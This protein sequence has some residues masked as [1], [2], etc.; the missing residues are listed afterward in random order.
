MKKEN[1]KEIL[2]EISK[3]RDS[4]HKL[5]DE[6]KKVTGEVLHVSTQL[7]QRINSYFKLSKR[8]SIG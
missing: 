2:K 8:E 1:S 6:N 5:F 7:D 3:L 4:M